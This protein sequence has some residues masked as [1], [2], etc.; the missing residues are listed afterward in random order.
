MG[1]RGVARGGPGGPPLDELLAGVP[2]DVQT[3]VAV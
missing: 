3:E 1:N 2:Q